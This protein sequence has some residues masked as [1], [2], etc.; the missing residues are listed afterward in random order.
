MA[1][2]T[3]QRTTNHLLITILKIYER[4]KLIMVVAASVTMNLLIN[5]IQGLAMIHL[6]L[7]TLLHPTDACTNASIHPNHFTLPSENMLK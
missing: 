7:P 2:L 6:K 4:K 1:P 3:R 5:H